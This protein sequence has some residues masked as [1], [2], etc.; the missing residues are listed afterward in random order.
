MRQ[1]LLATLFECNEALKR[2]ARE[3]F[4]PATDRQRRL[5]CQRV[6]AVFDAQYNSHTYSTPSMGGN[7]NGSSDNSNNNHVRCA[8]VRARAC[9]LCV[10]EREAI[11]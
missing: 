1:F 9:V 5:F 4:W 11:I 3:G 10:V 2:I 7:S 6:K 8:V